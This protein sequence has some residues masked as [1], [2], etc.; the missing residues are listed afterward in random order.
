MITIPMTTTQ[1][2]LLQATVSVSGVGLPVTVGSDTAALSASIGATYSMGEYS[3]Y[4][5]SYTFTPGAEAQVIPT[6]DLVL[7][8]DITIEAIPSNYGLI[9]WNGSYLTVS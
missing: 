6:E 4:E 3:H 1:D 7:D 5:G 2:V 8:S 9:T